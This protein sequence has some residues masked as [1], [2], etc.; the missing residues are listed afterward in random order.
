MSTFAVAIAIQRR[1]ASFSV[2]RSLWS[3]ACKKGNNNRFICVNNAAASTAVTATNKVQSSFAY[4]VPEGTLQLQNVSR[5]WFSTLASTAEAEAETEELEDEIVVDE[6]EIL[7]DEEEYSDDGDSNDVI[8][9]ANEAARSFSSLDLHPRTLELLQSQSMNHMTEIQSKTWDA[10][11]QGQDVVGRSRT[12]SGKT[13]AFLL[14]PLE[15]II[16]DIEKKN[17]E[18]SHKKD[19]RIRMLIISPT[20]ELASQIDSTASMLTKAHRQIVSNQVLYG[21]V[22]KGKDLQ[23]FDRR[24]PTILTTTPGRLLDHLQSSVLRDRAIKFSETLKNID[25]LVLDEMDRLLDLGF[26]RDIQQILKFLPP[27]NERQTLLFSATV[28]P[29]VKKEIRNATQSNAVTVDCIQDEDPASHTVNTVQQSHVVLPNAKQISGVVETIQYLMNAEYN[30]EGEVDD[31]NNK[32]PKIV[33]FFNT[34]AQVTFYA[35]LLKALGMP[36]VL[37]LHSKINQDQRSKRSDK[38]RKAPKDKPSIL[39]TSD[40]SARGGKENAVFCSTC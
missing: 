39:L 12:G 13:L 14:P 1:T 5:N 6:E 25:V 8:D 16:R 40:V 2:K 7:L 10:V 30:V 15:K 19:Q 29:S 36:R 37:E 27:K 32:A 22:P 17:E 20:R 18:G 34:T 3:L 38:F 4:R 33:V 23:Q 21:G 26:S 24:M 28:P 31:K 35:A 9:E 11:Y